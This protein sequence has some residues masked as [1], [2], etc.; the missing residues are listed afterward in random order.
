[1]SGYRA[2]PFFLVRPEGRIHSGVKVSYTPDRE[3]EALTERQ[4]DL[5]AVTL[6]LDT[7]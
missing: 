4:G 1:M 3:G 7:S 2:W 5:Y 6:I